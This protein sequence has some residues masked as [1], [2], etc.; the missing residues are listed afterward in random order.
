MKLKKTMFL[1]A[2]AAGGLFAGGSA[3]AQNAT[4]TIPAMAVSTNAPTPR[5]RIDLLKLTPD[6][7]TKVQAILAK[8]RLEMGPIFG[9]GTLSQADKMAKIKAI[10]DDTTA[11]LKLILTSDQFERWMRMQPRMRRLTPP[12]PLMGTNTP[13][14]PAAPAT[15]GQ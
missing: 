13:A 3:F 10:R 15:P 6:Q 4:N 8:Q 9:D 5:S 2:L 7:K 12:P 11:Q 14:A 1:A